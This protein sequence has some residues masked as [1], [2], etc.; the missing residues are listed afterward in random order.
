MAKCSLAGEGT[1]QRQVGG[2]LRLEAGD[3]RVP[4]G[5]S[6]HRDSLDV[7]YLTIRNEILCVRHGRMG[8]K[9]LWAACGG[10]R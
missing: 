10:A 3:N 1:L 6:I 7:E 8:Q 2:V 5:Y 9:G 4:V